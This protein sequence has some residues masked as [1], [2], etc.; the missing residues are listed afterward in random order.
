MKILIAA[1]LHIGANKF[2]T[3]DEKWNQPVEEL[4]NYAIYNE[5]DAVAFAGD[6]FHSRRPSPTSQQFM[7]DQIL[8]LKMKG[9]AFFGADGNH[10]DEVR[11]DSVSATWAFVEATGW[12]RK[13]PAQFLVGETNLVF[14]PWVTPQAYEVSDGTLKSQL[15]LTQAVAL[16]ELNSMIVADRKNVLIGHAMVSYGKGENDLAPSPGLQ[17]AGKDVV[18][19]YNTL[20]NAFDAVYLGH[21]H[22]PRM[23]GYVGSSQPTDWGDA[24]QQKSF[25]V[26]DTDEWDSQ[27]IP[28][29]TSLRLLDARFQDFGGAA[30]KGK[31]YDI[32][33]WKAHIRA[34]A[35][36][37]TPE[38]IA[39]TRKWMET[40][41]DRVESIEVTK[42]RVVVQRVATDTPLAAMRPEE[43]AD[44]WIRNA[45]L[46]SKTAADVKSKFQTLIV[47][48]KKVDL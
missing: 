43:A 34:D 17:W 27:K 38:Q 28:Y 1:D 18:F 37:I 29:K 3:T 21:V 41:C 42:E 36:D 12:C 4:V 44:A 16:A 47:S 32:G 5:L 46:G 24:P 31:H 7:Y 2:K 15:E 33:R 19:D 25:V 14:L 8:K 6:V 39:D 22:D 26:L 45:S 13:K 20:A 35:E 11:A 23:E 48:A 40:F 30:M 9:I 10:D